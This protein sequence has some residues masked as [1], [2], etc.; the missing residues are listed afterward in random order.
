[1]ICSWAKSRSYA[2]DE[3][4]LPQKVKCEMLHVTCWFT[5]IRTVLKVNH[6]VYIVP[7][8]YGSQIYAD[9]QWKLFSSEHDIGGSNL[10]V[11]FLAEQKRERERVRRAEIII[12]ETE[13][14]FLCYCLQSVYLKCYF[15]FLINW[16]TK[17][18][19]KIWFSFLYWSWDTKRETK[20]VHRP[21]AYKT[22]IR[23]SIAFFWLKIEFWRYF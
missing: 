23:F 22:F 16:N 18:E 4:R 14:V 5:C 13:L 2:A 17:L 20:S 11:T 1:M 12:F 3:T 21:S 10:Q 7:R 19:I 15:I 8:W 9:C 6:L